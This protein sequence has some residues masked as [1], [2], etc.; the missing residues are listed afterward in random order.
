MVCVYDLWQIF[1]NSPLDL[2]IYIILYDSSRLKG[3]QPKLL[4]L[5]PNGPKSLAK[6]NLFDN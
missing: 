2:K 5:R 3:N 4:R 1:S 6:D